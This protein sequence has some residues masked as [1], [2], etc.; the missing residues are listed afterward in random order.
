[1]ASLVE[2]V[3]MCVTCIVWAAVS[4][5]P[6]SAEYVVAPPTVYGEKVEIKKACKR[7]EAGIIAYPS[8]VS[9]TSLGE[10]EE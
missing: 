3:L 5:L 9:N 4:H 2:G 10:E 7:Q 1:M 8:F 6:G